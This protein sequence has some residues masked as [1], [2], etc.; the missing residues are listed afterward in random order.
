MLDVARRV[1][2]ASGENLPVL[3]RRLALQ[4]A[5]ANL[6][7]HIGI[8]D[9]QSLNA[10]VISRPVRGCPSNARTARGA[11]AVL[12][13]SSKSLCDKPCVSIVSRLLSLSFKGAGND[14]ALRVA[15][16]MSASRRRPLQRG[17]EPSRDGCS[18]RLLPNCVMK[19]GHGPLLS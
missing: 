4:V 7:R 18:I 10:H 13:A 6:A 17:G 8:E 12:P 1:A 11:S 16:R 14:L 15:G 2:T 5:I 9:A 3:P 19:F